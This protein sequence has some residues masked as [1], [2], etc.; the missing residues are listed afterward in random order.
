MTSKIFAILF[1][2]V[3]STTA[4]AGAK[5]FAKDSEG[6]KYTI[7]LDSK[8]VPRSDG[9]STTY[10]TIKDFRKDVDGVFCIKGTDA[11]IKK[12]L[13][14][15]VGAADGDGDSY[16]EL[17]KIYKNETSW[18]VLAKISDESAETVE[19]FSFPNCSR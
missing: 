6:L 18:A 17:K 19:R 11:D 1:I 13:T 3:I 15:L 5:I 4:K 16:A 14:A 7:E 12:L 2:S 9:D 10:P 8:K